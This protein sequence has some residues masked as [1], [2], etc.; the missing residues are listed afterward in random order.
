MEEL[1]MLIDQDYSA[2]KSQLVIY[3]DTAKDKLTSKAESVLQAKLKEVT[4]C[5]D[6]VSAVKSF[7]EV[8]KSQ[9][10]QAASLRKDL[11]HS[12][13]ADEALFHKIYNCINTFVFEEKI[14]KTSIQEA[15]D[16]KKQFKSKKFEL[17]CG[18]FQDYQLNQ[19]D[20]L[21]KLQDLLNE[22][23]DASKKTEIKT[24]FKE[25]I[26]K[27]FTSDIEAQ[28]IDSKQPE[29][30][31]VQKPPLVSPVKLIGNMSSQATEAMVVF[32]QKLCRELGLSL[33]SSKAQSLVGMPVIAKL[34]GKEM[35]KR[36]EAKEK[37]IEKERLA[38]LEAQKKKE[39]LALQATVKQNLEAL[40][41]KKEQS[42]DKIL[43]IETSFTDSYVPPPIATEATTSGHVIQAAKSIIIGKKQPEAT[44][45]DQ[46]IHN[47][48]IAEVDNLLSKLSMIQLHYSQEQK[49]IKKLEKLSDLVVVKK[50]DTT[51][52]E[53][54]K[55]AQPSKHTVRTPNQGPTQDSLLQNLMKV[56]NQ[57]LPSFQPYPTS[58]REN[59]KR[60]HNR[61][62]E[63]SKENCH[64]HEQERR[65]N[66]PTG[67][68]GSIENTRTPTQRT[69]DRLDSRKSK[70]N[71]KYGNIE[72]QDNGAM[73]VIQTMV[74]NSSAE[75][76]QE[77]ATYR[78]SKSNLTK[79]P[80]QRP[81]SKNESSE[82]LHF[83]QEQSSNV[84]R[85]SK[86]NI[87]D[88]KKE[89]KLF[90]ITPDCKVLPYR[91]KRS[92]EK[93][94]V[95]ENHSEYQLS[96]GNSFYFTGAE[97][98]DFI[99]VVMQKEAFVSSILIEPPRLT[100][101]Q[102]LNLAKVDGASLYTFR[103]D[104]WEKV[105]KLDF[106]GQNQVVVPVNIRASVFRIAHGK[107]MDSTSP[108]GIG[109]LT[110]MG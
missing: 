47:P 91:L 69:D 15:E 26:D 30:T 104:K 67:Y 108:L 18:I 82:E 99:E 51:K 76:R 87:P 7:E 17:F 20:D 31:K 6:K 24:N 74:L 52:P 32:T 77:T 93:G 40:K 89:G 92:D 36:K 49:D 44:Q 98:T 14:A 105:S 83:T 16:N 71:S 64:S 55:A 46:E 10:E 73:Q 72:Y 8:K 85:P 57:K 75:N 27:V 86:T 35:E 58:R 11:E 84:L 107:S 56:E 90:Q 88:S 60:E 80:P 103:N 54:I 4:E 68:T 81:F 13:V 28:Q 110:V 66:N 34:L 33:E 79:R 94:M 78:N 23:Y 101:D 95:H 65:W 50:E 42:R 100:H 25:K 22:F 96:K 109:R 12:P 59:M 106:K 2:L 29:T 21:K 9:A 37:A 48:K 97:P 39:K 62:Y 19:K 45:N 63:S 53:E 41:K 43:G 102:N 70:E 3:L 1:I 5:I 38:L 61:T